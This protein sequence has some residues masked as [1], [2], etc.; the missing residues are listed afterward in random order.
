MNEPDKEVKTKFKGP[1]E[2]RSQAAELEK[3]AEDDTPDPDTVR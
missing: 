3:T 2:W 1:G